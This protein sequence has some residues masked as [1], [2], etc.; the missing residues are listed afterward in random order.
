M[1]IAASGMK[2]AKHGN[3]ASSSKCGTADCL[4]ALGVNIEQSPEQCKFLLETVGMCFFYAQNYHDSMKY[5]GSLRKELGFRTVFNIL[6]PLTN[7]ASPSAQLLGVYDPSLVEP[8]AKVLISLG[9]KRGM[10]VYGKNKLDEISLS[11][12]TLICEFKNGW[13]KTYEVKPE[14]FGMPRV[15]QAEFLG[16]EPQKNAAITRGILSGSVQG[17]KRNAVLL[18]AGAALYLGGKAPSIGEGAEYAATLIDKGAA[19]EVLNK[20]IQLS[21]LN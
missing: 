2:V 16:G 17:S 8:L 11:D 19:L 21:N 5:V 1:V 9:V 14:D 15:S 4:E 7:P 13:Y 12:E 10:V 3:R 18:N 20:L 6:G